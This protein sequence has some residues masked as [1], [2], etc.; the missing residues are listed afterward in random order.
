MALQ[1]VELGGQV[2]EEVA[3][4]PYQECTKGSVIAEGYYV[5]DIA[6]VDKETG[7][8][9]FVAHKI[10]G[11]EKT[12]AIYKAGMLTKALSKLGEGAYVRISYFGKNR[13][14]AGPSKGKFAHQFDIETDPDAPKCDTSAIPADRISAPQAAAADDDAPF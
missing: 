10:R 14:E 9:R 11:K 1:K 4:L 13:I 7:E 8:P 5:G 6:P 12:V 3:F 2:R